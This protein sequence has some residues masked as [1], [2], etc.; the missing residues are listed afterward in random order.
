MENLNDNEAISQNERIKNFFDSLAEGWDAASDD[1]S[2]K[3]RRILV[4]SEFAPGMKVLDVACGTGVMFPFFTEMGAQSVTG[5]DI[6]DKMIE[7]AS[8]KFAA[9][10]AVKLIC[11][12]ITEEEFSGYD[13]VCIYSAYPHFFDKDKLRDKACAALNP[14]GRFVVAHSKSKEQ[15]NMHH[16]GSAM[17]VSTHLMPAAE[18]AKRWGKLFDI[19]CVVDNN[20]M[21]VLSGCK[22]N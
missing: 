3:I 4:L 2:E 5:V 19:D 16:S 14:C 15:I 10:D 7:K 21:Y 11:C 17:P 8:E 22:K 9:C 13:F 6:S 1:K 18:E 12:D 20:E